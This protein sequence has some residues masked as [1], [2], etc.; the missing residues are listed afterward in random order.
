MIFD[1]Y[2]LRH[3]IP[4][5]FVAAGMFVLLFLLV[6]LFMNMVPYL[7]NFA[8]MNQILLVSFY[9]IPKSFTFA[10]PVSLLFAVAYTLGDLYARNE[11][12]TVIAS[13]V[14]FWRLTAVFMVIGFFMSIFAF[15]F[16]DNVVIPTYKIKNTMTRTL[17]GQQIQ[18]NNSDIVIKTHGGNR[19]YSVDFYDYENLVL[20]GVS[21]IEKDDNGN[22]LLQIR[23]PSARWFEGHWVFSNA[24]IYSWQDGTITVNTL[25]PSDKYDEDP[26][27]FKRGAVNPAELSAKDA[28]ALADDLQEAGLP[29]TAA[30][31][32]VYHRYSFST[33]SFIVVILSISLGSHFRKN[34]LMMSLLVSIL[35][36]VL[37]YVVEM[38]T[39]MMGRLGYLSPFLGAWLPVFLFVILGVVLVRYAKT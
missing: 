19:V 20:N 37:F 27:L 7:D 1:R 29:Y 34:I 38:V 4:V 35:S 12:T 10:L 32:D 33:V 8:T 21:V 23:A 11:L 39:M 15:F 18:E 25:I 31:A 13:G 2:I 22:F 5:F 36:A 30:L 3:F 16:E 14:P 24:V 9:Y 28:A 26:E 6:D 17:K